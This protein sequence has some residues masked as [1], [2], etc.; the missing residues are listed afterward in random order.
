M[1][2]ITITSQIDFEIYLDSELGKVGISEG[3]KFYNS[4]HQVCLESFK[5]GLKAGKRPENKPI[6]LKG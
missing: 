5:I 6:N 1:A 3:N 4:I 2:E